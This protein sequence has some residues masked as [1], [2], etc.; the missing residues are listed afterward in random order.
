[1]ITQVNQMLIF[2]GS[3]CFIKKVHPKKVVAVSWN[4]DKMIEVK[5]KDI[6][7]DPAVTTWRAKIGKRLTR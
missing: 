7:Y 4:G 1:M 5:T 6:R 3:I 2:K